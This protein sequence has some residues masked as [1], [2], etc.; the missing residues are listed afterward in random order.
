MMNPMKHFTILD[1]YEQHPMNYVSWYEVAVY[2]A[3]VGKRLPTEAE[4]EVAAKGDD[5]ENPRAVPLGRVV[6]PVKRQF[7]TP[8]KH[9]V[10]TDLPK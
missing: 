3:H 10:Q 4:W 2:C 7:T 8:M 9:F 1:G 6:G 5:I